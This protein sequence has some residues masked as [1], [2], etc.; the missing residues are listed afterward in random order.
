MEMTQVLKNQSPKNNQP[1]EVVLVNRKK[2]S[3]VN[4]NATGFRVTST[5][6]TTLNPSAR[7]SSSSASAVSMPSRRMSAKEVQSVKL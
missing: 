1:F 6:G 5:H 4:R 7:K 2:A 3:Q